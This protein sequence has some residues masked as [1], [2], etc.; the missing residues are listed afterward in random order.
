[1]SSPH[2]SIAEPKKSSGSVSNSNKLSNKRVG[3]LIAFVFCGK[4]QLYLMI[5]AG[6]NSFFFY[7][8]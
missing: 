4:I 7:V 5:M 6:N 8:D 2:R 1:M 3:S